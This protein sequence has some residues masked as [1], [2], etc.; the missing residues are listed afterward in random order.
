MSQASGYCWVVICKN[1]WFH[2]R[3]NLFSGHKILLGETDALTPCPVI[4]Q[5]LMVRCDDCGKEYVYN[6]LQ[7]FRFE[8]EIT[9][10][11][12]PHPLFR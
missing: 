7:V 6:P 10:P 2:H 8:T 4:D 11:F 1:R 5:L 3:Q 12:I 9:E